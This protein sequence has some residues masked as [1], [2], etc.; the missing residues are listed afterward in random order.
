MADVQAIEKKIHER[1]AEIKDPIGYYMRQQQEKAKSGPGLIEGL[2]ELTDIL[3]GGDPFEPGKLLQGILNFG[4]T[5]LSS[6][7]PK[8]TFGDVSVIASDVVGAAL[9]SKGIPGRRVMDNALISNAVKNSPAKSA[10]A[11]TAMNI[12]ARGA[13]NETYDMIN[14][15]TRLFND[16]PNLTEAMEKDETLRNLYDMRNEM[17]FP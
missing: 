1:Q 14:Q 13:A 3:P 17:M 5:K 10:T 4:A 11:L 12:F 8:A 15:I 16:I 7:D 2:G 6:K 9:L